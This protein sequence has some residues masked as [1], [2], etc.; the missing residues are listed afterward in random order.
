MAKNQSSSK[1]TAATSESADKQNPAAEADQQQGLTGVGTD[2]GNSATGNA[3]PGI[4][5]DQE[6]DGGTEQ[7]APDK[8]VQEGLTAT[9]VARPADPILWDTSR[10]AELASYFAAHILANP[11]AHQML[12]G[13]PLTAG[14][15]SDDDGES[16]TKGELLAKRTWQIAEDYSKRLDQ[17]RVDYV[18]RE[19]KELAGKTA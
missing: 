2:A 4:N 3:D 18:K 17:C 16:L 13:N 14:K 1:N 6:A 5:P 10:I 12:Y 9:E 7:Q 11:Q 15:V 8:K 19:Q